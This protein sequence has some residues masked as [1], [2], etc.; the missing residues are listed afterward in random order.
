MPVE[1]LNLSVV[2][3]VDRLD[4]VL[5]VHSIIADTKLGHRCNAPLGVPRE[6]ARSAVTLPIDGKG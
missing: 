4:G 1:L 5:T 6:V 3:V 2:G